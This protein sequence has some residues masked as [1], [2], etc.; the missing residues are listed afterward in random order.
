MRSDENVSCL[1]TAPQ[2]WADDGGGRLRCSHTTKTAVDLLAQL[3]LQEKRLD[4]STCD[5]YTATFIQNEN[6]MWSELFVT[7]LVLGHSAVFFTDN[8]CKLILA[9]VSA[10][11]ILSLSSW[12]L[13]NFS[14]YWSHKNVISSIFPCMNIPWASGVEPYCAPALQLFATSMLSYVSIVNIIF[15]SLQTIE[16][17]TINSLHGETYW[18][19]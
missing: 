3:G 19:S 14:E 8:R 12:L 1:E 9:I 13:R 4:T 10:S 16:T 2:V 7:T 18:A 15:Y 17:Y 11:T 6:R 5:T